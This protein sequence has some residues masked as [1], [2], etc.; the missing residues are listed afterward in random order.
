MQMYDPPHPGDF[1]NEVYLEP[2][3]ISGDA[4]AQSLH[5]APATM[6]CILDGTQRITPE[7]ALILSRG[8]GSSAESWLRMQKIYDD[9]QATVATQK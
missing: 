1:I 2:F 6:R 3:G 5:I 8:L 7:L 9:W 4:C